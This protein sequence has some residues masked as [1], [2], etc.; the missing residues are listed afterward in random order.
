MEIFDFFKK[1]RKKDELAAILKKAVKEK[2]FLP[3]FYKKFLV[4]DV[5]IL[6]YDKELPSGQNVFDIQKNLNIIKLNDKK[7][8][9]FS[10]KKRIFDNN[11][12]K[13]GVSFTSIN[14]RELLKITKGETLILNPYSKINKEMPSEEIADALSG[15]MPGMDIKPIVFENQSE[16]I[17]GL[18]AERPKEM[19][20][21]IKIYCKE[22]SEIEEVYLALFQMPE[23]DERPSF[24][25][26]VE[27]AG[28][29]PEIFGDL[30]QIINSH[31][32]KDENFEITPLKG[33]SFED[34]FTTID[35]IYSK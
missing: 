11:I 13:D 27:S 10:S 8:P 9:V 14:G 22:M 19:I 31:L 7:I 33:S 5:Y 16:V 26:A 4:S 23:K 30:A 28:N 20:E 35:P 1:I 2:A 32:E 24:I 18:P 15:E 25:V 6:V 29:L 21:S 12:I 34:F 3:N 17:I